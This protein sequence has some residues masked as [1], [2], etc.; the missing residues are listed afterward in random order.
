MK[1]NNNEKQTQIMLNI[2][3]TLNCDS[4]KATVLN[5]F[6]FFVFL[7]VVIHFHSSFF[8]KRAAKLVSIVGDG[9]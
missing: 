3:L 1:V 8:C 5:P 7:K 4:I 6:F 9:V 2:L